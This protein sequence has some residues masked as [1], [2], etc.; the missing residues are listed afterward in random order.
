MSEFLGQTALTISDID[1]QLAHT[2]FVIVDLETAGGKPGDAG[3]TE[4]GAV[5]VRGGE[6]LGEFRTFCHPGVPIPAFI[7]VLTGIT[8]HH[9]AT[10]P[11][12]ASAVIE[13][14]AFAGFDCEDPPVLV[15]HNAP[16]DV[17]FLKSAC[18]KFEIHWPAP[19]IVDTVI[20][21]RKILRKDEVK[22]KKLATLARFFS[23]PVS[24]THRALD[25]ARATVSVLHGLIERVGNLGVHDLAGLT[26]FDGPGTQRR[27]RKRHLATDLPES[28]GVYIFYDGA[29][30]ALYVGTSKNIRKR[31]MS[32]F[33]AA[34]TR[35]RMTTMVELAQ[36]VQGFVCETRLEATIRELR[37]INELRP[38]YNARSRNPEKT[39]WLTL[40][41]EKF[42]RASLIRQA[43]LPT[44]DRI[45][46]G[47][48]VNQSWAQLAMDALHETTKLRQCKDRITS[49]SVMSP[50]ALYE[51]D[52]CIAPCLP[53]TQATHYDAIVTKSKKILAGDSS[54]VTTKFM[55]SIKKFVDLE[56]FEEA[57]LSRD[58]MHALAGGV[59]RS[60]KLRSISLIP[61]LLAAQ[62][63]E[64]G[65]WD[66]HAITYG[67]LAGA[68]QAPPG[69]NPKS[70]LT[71]LKSMIAGEVRLPTLVSETELLL[72]WLGDG[73]TRLVEIAAGHTWQHP[74]TAP[75]KAQ[76]LLSS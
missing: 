52:R 33:T 69:Q 1:Q 74:I 46:I 68:I 31:V 55:G 67:R 72:K 5:K 42:P 6:V 28:P 4:I 48:F 29:D 27:R 24:P 45:F 53:T 47:P 23:A 75:G 49:K 21:A 62:L 30:R 56:K 36:R 39:I 7:S 3:I 44:E 2:T 12:V 43:T 57:A 71:Q 17:G 35:A 16:F 34:E 25:D 26:T 18:A 38:T 14:L 54:Q 8:N 61:F 60:T 22:D 15:A 41:D 63:N 58:R 37:I 59:H 20:L 65:G 51:M 64:L 32:Y 76:G 66:I 50:C 19:K 73:N 13:F 11:N 40:T 10:A 70:Y 9:V